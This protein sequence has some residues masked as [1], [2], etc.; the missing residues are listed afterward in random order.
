[1]NNCWS[2]AQNS[3]RTGNIRELIFWDGVG[4]APHVGCVFLRSFLSTHPPGWTLRLPLGTLLCGPWQNLSETVVIWEQYGRVARAGSSW[5]RSEAS[6][7]ILFTILSTEPF[8][9]A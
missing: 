7:H 4:N 5:H 3:A 1:M 6:G 9:S 8:Q 2:E